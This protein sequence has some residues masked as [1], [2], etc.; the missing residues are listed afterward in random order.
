M[1]NTCTF[2]VGSKTITFN[3]EERLHSASPK[4]TTGVNRKKTLYTSRGFNFTGDSRPE[5]IDV[6]YNSCAGG[7]AVRV[8][9]SPWKKWSSVKTRVTRGDSNFVRMVKSFR[10]VGGGMNEFCFQERVMVN[11]VEETQTRKILRSAKVCK[12]SVD[13]IELMLAALV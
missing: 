7:K 8:S 9:W 11:F 3:M 6:I 13:F 4:N 12:L 5:F 10:H 1:K 2:Q